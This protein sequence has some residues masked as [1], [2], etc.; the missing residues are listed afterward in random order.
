MPVAS[1]SLLKRRTSSLK[2]CFC[3]SSSAKR[4]RR[5][6][7]FRG[8]NNGSQWALNRRYRENEG[9]HFTQL[10][11]LPPL[12][13]KWCAV[14]LSLCLDASFSL[15]EPFKL[16]SEMRQLCGICLSTLPLVS[17]LAAMA[18]RPL[19][20]CHQRPFYRY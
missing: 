9:E 17:I 1:N 5:G 14:S 12:C 15:A 11:Q 20:G 18:G 10:L 6:A 13:A 16:F 19:R 2:L 4:R 8:P 3:S 7:A